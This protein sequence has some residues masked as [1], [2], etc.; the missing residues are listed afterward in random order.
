MNLLSSNDFF[1]EK[2]PD[3]AHT[4]NLEGR[5]GPDSAVLPT[6][7]ASRTAHLHPRVDRPGRKLG[8][9]LTVAVVALSTVLVGSQAQA[10]VPRALPNPVYGITLDDVSGASTARITK[11]RAAIT[12][13]PRKAT[14]RV[15]F[16]EDTG[17]GEYA[18]QL[19]QLHPDMY[20]MGELSDSEYM[21]Q[22]SVQQYKD[23]AASFVGALADR[24]DLWEV[25][26]EVNGNWTG[27]YSDVAAKIG[28]A[29]DVV[30]AAGERSAL[31]LWYNPGCAGSSKELDPVGF[32]NQYVPQ[33]MRTGLEYVTIS[34]YET[35]C[36]N[37]RPSAA[38]LTTLFQQL[39]TLYPNASLGF[40]E[41][42]LPDAASTST[43]AKAQSI[44]AYYYGLNIDLPYYVGGYFYWYFAEDAVAKTKPV[45]QTI[46][47]GMT[48]Y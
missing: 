36:N 28:G 38:K 19:A 23:R 37:Y 22:L 14:A 6:G 34:Y 4:G 25:G 16:D 10:A 43:T 24:V 27:K 18:T 32:T 8:R 48:T 47:N 42:G 29:F 21:G 15:V 12:A 40:G 13:L 1:P 3:P 35:E 7:R 41:I 5:G 11:E 44:A 31:T 33:R 20:I 30:E 2:H 39:H 45:W 26:N 9:V 46:A 17:P